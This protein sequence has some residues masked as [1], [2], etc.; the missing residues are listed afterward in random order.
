MTIHDNH[1]PMFPGN[2]ASQPAVAFADDTRIIGY[3]PVI[4]PALIQA[5]LPLDAEIAT[6][7]TEYRKVCVNILNRK[8]DRLLVVV[9]PCS[10]HD[11]DSAIEYARLLKS[12]VA[13]FE[14]DLFIVMRAYLEKPRT[15][16]GWKGMINDP[17]IDGS[18]K[19]NQGLKISR[20]LYL[21][22]AKLGIPIASEQLDT[23]SP[24][25]LADL[26]SWGA[27]GART[28]ESQL[29]R[30]LASGLSFPLGFK[31]ATDGNIS[32]AVDAIK[33]ASYSHHFLS[34]TKQGVVAIVTTAGNDTTH[35]IL[36]GGNLGPNYK[37]KHIAETK[38]LLRKANV[39]ESIMVDC[40]HS[41]SSKNHKNQPIVARNIA[42]QI[43]NG[44]R[45]ITGAMIESHIYEGKQNIPDS[46]PQ[47]LKYGVS[48]TDACIGWQD[49]V[50]TLEVLAEAVKKRREHV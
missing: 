49:T 1:V 39:I 16:L 6:L 40:S 44:E 47:D 45:A 2:G 25:Y 42:E 34:I 10:L 21:E 22:F 19:I 41:N 33:A 28:T 35:V 36:R 3:D 38:E 13:R 5:E 8:D 37:A 14:R 43:A 48:I 17:H 15:I 46:G 12:V 4:P 26:V 9:G 27:I 7:I 29:H 50:S 23:I 11:K 24:Q 30:E 32:I 18:F 31:N 20:G